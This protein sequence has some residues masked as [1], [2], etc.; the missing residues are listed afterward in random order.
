MT[1]PWIGPFVRHS[2]EPILSPDPQ[3]WFEKAAVYNPAAVSFNDEIYMLYRAEDSHDDY[4]SR[5]GLARSRDG[6]DFQRHGENPVVGIDGPLYRSERR[7]CEDPRLV[8]IEGT[9]YLT[10]TAWDGHSVGL[11]MATSTDLVRWVKH[12]VIVPHTKSGAILAQKV[13]GEYLMYFGDTNIWLAT[14][15]DLL[16]WKVQEEP[17]LRPRKDCFDSALVEPGPPPLLTDDGIL[18]IYNSSTGT[19]YNVGQVLFDKDDPSKVL[20]RTDEPCLSPELAW[21]KWGK[22]NQVVFA[23]GLVQ[24]DGTWYL[25]YGGADKC[26]GLATAPVR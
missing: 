11:S 6:I 26:I 7:G 2:S 1:T 10:Y 19:H 15:S 18:L 14:S 8:E 24:K 13:N 12:G 23:E 9:F 16:H 20:A 21:E 25:Y 4:I 22:V 3:L 17:V 5:L